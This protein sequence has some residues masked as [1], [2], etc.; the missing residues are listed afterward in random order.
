MRLLLKKRCMATASS[1]AK[2][3]INPWF[4]K[5]CPNQ[6]RPAAPGMLARYAPEVTATEIWPTPP[7]MLFRAPPKEV[8]R[9]AAED[10]QGSGR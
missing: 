4:R 6:P 7:A 8:G 3:T 5:I 1:K 10:G 9:A 2:Y